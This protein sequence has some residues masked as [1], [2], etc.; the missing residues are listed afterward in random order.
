[1]AA[2]I[3]ARQQPSCVVHPHHPAVDHCDDCGRRFRGECL[4]RGGPQLLCRECWTL[5]PVRAAQAAD[6][7]RLAHRLVAALRD[8]ERRA[9]VVA[10]AIIAAV[11]GLLA[12][13]SGATILDEGGRAQMAEPV[14][15]AVVANQL[16]RGQAVQTDGTGRLLAMVPTPAPG[17]TRIPTLIGDPAPVA[18]APGANIFALVDGRAG[19]T[20]P[21][22]RS[23]PGRVALDVSF[24]TTAPVLTGRVLFGHSTDAPPATWANDVEVWTSPSLDDSSLSYAGR[25]SLQQTTEAQSF[26]FGRRQVRSVLLRVISNHG[27]T[28]STSLAEFALVGG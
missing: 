4:V 8:R 22:W 16:L 24:T 14:A 5:T 18:G 19:G 17:P 11:L 13:S 15:R 28:D 2:R 21:A 3:L 25:W 7:A 27:S 26:T 6:K 9:S 1:M 10:G 12:L 23:A 20:A